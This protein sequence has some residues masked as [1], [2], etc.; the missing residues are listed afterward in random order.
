MAVPAVAVAIGT[1]YFDRIARAVEGRFYRASVAGR[2]IVYGTGV[3][4][5]GSGAEGAWLNVIALI[6]AFLLPGI[7]LFLAWMIA[8]YA[9]GRGLFVAVAMRRMPRPLAESLYRANRTVI[10]VQGAVLAL[11][12]YVSILN[13]LIPIIGVATMVMCWTWL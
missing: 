10:W 9:I 8:A 3:G 7:G 1:M 6:L 5:R 11:T 12:A 4:R 2:R 13:L